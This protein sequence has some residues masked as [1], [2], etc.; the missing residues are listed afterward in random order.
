MN[1]IIR[2]ALL[3][4]ASL[5]LVGMASCDDDE[6]AQP[7]ADIAVNS[8]NLNI[9]ESVSVSFKG[10]ADQVVVYT[11]D[12]GHD[13]EKR[14]S[15][16]TGFVVNKGS[17]SYSYTSP[18]VYK[19]V[20][21]ATTS[22]DNAVD[23]RRDTCSCY[24]RVIDD[25]TEIQQISCP[26]IIYDEVFA[27]EVNDYDWFI[28][29][30]R[31]VKYKNS[32]PAISMS[33]KLKFHIGSDLS[34]IFIGDEKFDGNK[35]YDLSKPL[36]IRV[37]SDFGSQREYSLIAA[38]YPEFKSFSISGVEGKLLRSEF[39]YSYFEVELSIPESVDLTNVVPEFLTYEADEKVYIDNSEQVSGKSQVNM[40]TGE[41]VYRLVRKIGGSDDFTI[42]SKVVVKITRVK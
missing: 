26:Q 29:L 31:R 7:Y 35:K 10:V 8:N 6:A 9:N 12:A 34:K 33:Q 16:N 13:Y 38:Y 28:K 24:V 39:D 36:D 40:G 20:C 4:T 25:V 5:A 37:V 11:G 2:Y 21:V 27:N 23:I 22:N 15:S 17:F 30:P 42:E 32:N 18:G 41:V 3:L 19:L 1:R 14:S